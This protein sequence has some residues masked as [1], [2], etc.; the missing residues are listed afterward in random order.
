MHNPFYYPHS[1]LTKTSSKGP[2][3]DRN[4]VDYIKLEYQINS[5][6]NSL[7]E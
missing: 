5:P 4:L 2:I 1:R 6:T 7:M 3:Y